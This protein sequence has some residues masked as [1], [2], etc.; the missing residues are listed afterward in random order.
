MID[1][2]R[3]DATTILHRAIVECFYPHTH[4]LSLEPDELVTL[5]GMT[6]VSE[7]AQAWSE[8]LMR[9]LDAAVAEAVSDVVSRVRQAEGVDPF[10]IDEALG[11][12][13]RPEGE[14]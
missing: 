9:V 4:D 6:D 5:V 10:V 8:A 7:D 11:A 14:W 12:D 13:G 2:H 1:D 3:K